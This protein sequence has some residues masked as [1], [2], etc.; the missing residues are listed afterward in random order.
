MGTNFSVEFLTLDSLTEKAIDDWHQLFESVTDT[1][2]YQHPHWVRC[3]G[4][5]LLEHQMVIAFYRIDGELKVVMPLSE[6]VGQSRKQHPTHDHLTLNDLLIDNSFSRG[7]DLDKII[8]R[9]LDKH[10][11]SWWNW[12]LQNLPDISVL[13]RHLLRDQSASGVDC[14]NH[15]SLPGNILQ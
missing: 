7:G 13:A 2:F 12:R 11:D 3:V 8:T 5:N 1:R 6:Q 14:S 15:P 9:I 4:E 10:D